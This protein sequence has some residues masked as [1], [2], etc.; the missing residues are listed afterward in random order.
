MTRVTSRTRK[1]NE[2]DVQGEQIAR[3]RQ[4]GRMCNAYM[5]TCLLHDSK[6]GQSDS[7]LY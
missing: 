7:D 5:R 2:L 6:F 4:T 3:A 1:A